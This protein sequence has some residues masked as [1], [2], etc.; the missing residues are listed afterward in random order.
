M[1]VQSSRRQET[2]VGDVLRAIPTN[3]SAVDLVSLI[4]GIT[5]ATRDVG[6]LS[7]AGGASFSIH[8][9]PLTEGRLQVDGISVGAS[10]GGSGVSGYVADIGNAEEVTIT[11]SGSLGESEVGG[12]VMNVVPR[13]GGNTNHGSFFAGGAVGAMQGVNF[14]PALRDAGVESPNAFDQHLGCQ[15]VVR[16]SDRQGQAVVFLDWT[17]PGKCEVHR[18]HVAQ[19]EREQPGRVDVCARPHSTGK[20]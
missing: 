10:L 14:G 9:G 3:R 12:P 1:D 16:R 8:G 11:T 20:K 2:L 15:R 5:T 19:P 4:P 6:G 17:C 18:E 7:G 13:T